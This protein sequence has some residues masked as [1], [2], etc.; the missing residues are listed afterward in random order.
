VQRR[1]GKGA[2]RDVSST[3]TGA[4]GAVSATIKPTVAGEFA[5]RLVVPDSGGLAQGASA[6][7]AITAR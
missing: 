7:I 3:T 2:W 4:Q 5:Y 1:S 6:R